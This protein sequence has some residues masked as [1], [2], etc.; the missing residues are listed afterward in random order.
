[1]TE[2]EDIEY[3]ELVFLLLLCCRFWV[4]M[5]RVSTEHQLFSAENALITEVRSMICV[6]FLRLGM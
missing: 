5:T 2:L 1:M 4:R 6:A 3:Q